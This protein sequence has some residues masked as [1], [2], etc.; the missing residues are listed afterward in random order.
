MIDIHL[1]REKLEKTQHEEVMAGVEGFEPPNG[2]IKIL[3]SIINKLLILLTGWSPPL[4]SIP[5][6]TCH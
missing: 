1:P 5:H 3:N 4:P 2:G 6:Q